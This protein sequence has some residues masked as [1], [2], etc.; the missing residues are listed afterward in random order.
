MCEPLALL[1]LLDELER[2]Q[3]SLHD[4]LEAATDAQRALER[5][6]EVRQLSMVAGSRHVLVS[7][8]LSSPRTNRL[9]MRV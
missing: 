4:E 2:Q 5:K 7:V 3:R 8:S 6:V 1:M 9:L